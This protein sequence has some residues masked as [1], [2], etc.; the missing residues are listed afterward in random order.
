[1]RHLLALLCVFGAF[2]AHA[3]P[4]GEPTRLGL[5]VE[6][7]DERLEIT[8][9]DGRRLRLAGVQ[10]PRASPADPGRPARTRDLLRGWLMRPDLR[11]E[12]EL[13]AAVPDRWNRLPAR[14][15]APG[16][17]GTTQSV[18]EAL[19]EAGLARVQIDALMRP[20]L[21]ALLALEG[22]A[23]QDR[24]GLWTDPAFALASA[25]D[26]EAL[27]ARA[28][29]VLVVE[30]RVSAVGYTATRAYLNFGPIRTIDFAASIGRFNLADFEKGGT[31]LAS[32]SGKM[33]RVRGLL[34]T[35]FGPQIELADPEALE[36]AGQPVN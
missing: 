33:V 11:V 19:V 30:G 8:L 22:R 34:E 18:A 3:A 10:P 17:A 24:L 14:L 7:V 35:Q 2:P 20:C 27:A 32:L 9:E 21:R 13:L 26:R 5:R 6:A 29:E 23:R 15:F 31:P 28:G 1:M 36:I 25:A 12:L 4:C 16:G